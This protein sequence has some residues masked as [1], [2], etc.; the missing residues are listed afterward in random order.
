MADE[1]ALKTPPQTPVEISVYIEG[2]R[3]VFRTDE[4][5][6]I[7]T[8][9]KDAPGKSNCDGD[10]SK[11]WLPVKAPTIGKV[12]GDWT[13]IERSDK[14]AQWAYKGK[15]VYTYALDQPGKAAGDGVAGL[16]HVLNP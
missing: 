7:Y 5:L 3:F 6:A 4:P 2:G 15:P 10:C 8:Y 9:D 14:S 16:W 1:L 11:A 13:A 12:V